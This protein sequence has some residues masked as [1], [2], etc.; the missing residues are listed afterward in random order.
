VIWAVS[1]PVPDVL[2]ANDGRSFAVRGADGRLSLHHAGG[3]TFAMRE[4]LAADG[5]G[6]DIHD[7][8][9]G[10]GIGCD[11]SGCVGKLRDGALVAATLA[12]EAF[13]EDCR[14]AVLVIANR[15]PPPECAA[16]VVTRDLWRRRGAL[17]LRRTAAGFAVESVRP[18]N[19]DRPWSPA[20][21]PRGAPSETNAS[22]DIA[23]APR[24]PRDATPRPED[25]EADQ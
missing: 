4:W 24:A 12:P 13:E 18:Q 8:S 11:P 7:P 21:K 20:P 15:D 6:R 9:L 25:I 5:D 19:F 2:I 17:A 16:M 22:S 14:R 3:D 1:V 10:Q 23:S